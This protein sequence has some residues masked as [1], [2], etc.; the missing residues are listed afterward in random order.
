MDNNTVLYYLYVFLKLQLLIGLTV[1]LIVMLV[2]DRKDYEMVKMRKCFRKVKVNVLFRVE[3]KVGLISTTLWL[4]FDFS[5]STLH[6][7]MDF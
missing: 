4:Y 2:Y 7:F 5:F 1:S 3:V 6:P